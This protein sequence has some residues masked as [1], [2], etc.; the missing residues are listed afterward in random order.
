[1][2]HF[3][4]IEFI[5]THAE[6]INGSILIVGSK[7]YAYDEFD[8]RSVLTSLGFNHIIG[9]DISEGTGVDIV[10]D[11]V[12]PDAAFMAKY[13]GGFD[14]IFFME[15][16]THLSNPFVAA[17]H[18]NSLLKPGGTLFLSECIVRKISK[19][20]SDYWRFTF[21][22]LAVLFPEIAFNR[23][24]LYT[25][26]TR[27]KQPNLTPFSGRIPEIGETRN[28]Q[29]SRSGFLL[30]RIA[31]RWLNGPLFRV[32][33]FYPETTIYAVGKKQA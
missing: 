7:E 5:R 17:Q 6:K 19:M 8:I 20:P 25:A 27:L 32:S 13:N 15:I 22:G 14:T 11:I 1:M 4:Q 9:V 12:A 3:N 2:A 33:R 16:L 30:R 18:I 31:R 28:N 24:D 23:N 26:A 29:E 10:M 21:D